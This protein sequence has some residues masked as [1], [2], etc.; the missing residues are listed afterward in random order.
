MLYLQSVGT[1]QVSSVH[2]AAFPMGAVIALLWSKFEVFGQ[3]FIGFLQE[4]CP[5]ALPYYPK[6][7]KSESDINHLIACGYTFGK[8]NTLESEES[9]ISRMRAL[10]MIYGAIIQTNLSQNHPHGIRHAWKWLSRILNMPPRP[11]ITA[12]VLHAFIS[13]TAHKMYIV[14]KKQF[15]KLLSFVA[16]RY[17]PL[18]EKVSASQEVKKQTL[19][20]LKLFV[21][22]C[23]K[24]IS[25]K[26]SLPE[27]DGMIK[28]TLSL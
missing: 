15:A 12:A 21:E 9:Y 5:L 8:E 28:S 17:I 7:D 20:Q 6:K 23:R 4:K 22:E 27:A 13:V 10:I 14:Y 1:K 2:K 3:L 16:N 25:Q 24:Q 26:K 18:I 19:V 11:V